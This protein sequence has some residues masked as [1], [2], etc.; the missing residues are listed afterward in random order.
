MAPSNSKYPPPGKQPLKH[1]AL[2]PPKELE[3]CRAMT[4]DAI[5]DNVTAFL[6]E[7]DPSSTEPSVLLCALEADDPD[8]MERILACVDF[9]HSGGKGEE[10]QAQAERVRSQKGTEGCWSA[11]SDFVEYALTLCFDC[12]SYRC[13]RVLV[14]GLPAVR[15]A[16]VVDARRWR[17]YLEDDCEIG[18]YLS[19]SPG[20]Q[21]ARTPISP[22]A[23]KPFDIVRA[24]PRPG[25]VVD[26]NEFILL[27]NYF[28]VTV[29][30]TVKEYW[31]FQI[32][33]KLKTKDNNDKVQK[34]T[35]VKLR[36]LIQR[37]LK[38]LE[39]A[40]NV[41]ASDLKSI[42]VAVQKPNNLSY[43]VADQHEPSK[44]YIV[45]L[46]EA[47]KVDI[48]EIVNFLQGMHEK[49][50]ASGNEGM[51]S[52]DA[53]TKPLEVLD[54]LGLVLSHTIRVQ[55]GVITIGRSRF[56]HTK[57]PLKWLNPKDKTLAI[58]S[59]FWQSV[60]PANNHFLLNVNVSN[61]AFLPSMSLQEYIELSR[62]YKE[63]ED[64]D[65]GEMMREY[66]ALASRLVG[67]RVEYEIGGQKRFKTIK[68]LV[69]IGEGKNADVADVKGQRF[70]LKGKRDTDGKL[71]GMSTR[72]KE[73]FEK[74]S[75]GTN[76]YKISVK[77]YFRL[78]GF[79]VIHPC[80]LV[81]Q[82]A[83]HDATEYDRKL[84]ELLPVI[85]LGGGCYVGAELC[86]INR[87]QL[88]RGD[89]GAEDAAKMIT[90]TVLDPE[91][92]KEKIENAPISLRMK[93]SK[94]LN[95]KGITRDGERVREGVVQ[96]INQM[97]NDVGE[98]A[99]NDRK[100]PVGAEGVPFELDTFED[101]A[102]RL[103]EHFETMN[104][105][106]TG[107]PKIWLVVLPDDRGL[108]NS[109]YKF[110]KKLGDVDYG[111]HT[112]S[113]IRSKLLKNN[114]GSGSIRGNI[115]LKF[116][117]KAGGINHL[118]HTDKGAGKTS[119]GIEL[120]GAGRTMVVGYDVSHPT[121]VNVPK[122]STT[123]KEAGTSKG[124]KGKEKESEEL[125][126]SFVGLVASVDGNLGQWPAV[127]WKT[128]TRVEMLDRATLRRKFTTRLKLWEDKNK[129]LP[130]N[131]VV[132][133]DGVSEGQY[134]EVLDTEVSAIK[135]AF[136]EVYEEKRRP[137]PGLLFIVTVKRHQ[138]RFFTAQTT[139]KGP[140]GN[141]RP[142]LAVD[143]GITVSR[144]WDFYLQPHAAI[145]GK[146]RTARPIHY[147]VL[148][149]DF[150]RKRYANNAASALERMT[151]DM[152]YA[153]GRATKA[154]SI[155]P[156]VYYADLVCTRAKIH[157]E[158]HKRRPTPGKGQDFD[159]LEIHGRC[160]NSMY[161]I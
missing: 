50:R 23:I 64:M 154:V 59:G 140:N 144:Q 72:L 99:R 93:D 158:E 121:G 44:T 46:I 17:G 77:D 81:I 71:I 62:W 151:H 28:R 66:R 7:G 161:Y 114:Q 67:A 1:P 127:A 6:W 10:L 88:F 16:L 112:I 138:T 49:W 109:I 53:Y 61:A 18:K 131:I 120:I 80:L 122:G 134:K 13:L 125:P 76:E 2:P 25:H 115:A 156:P 104:R 85:D 11:L 41:F 30:A 149:D 73:E 34:P 74:G 42:V 31:R 142:G 56:F 87:W 33:V 14:T 137:P 118:V 84:D 139:P 43:E 159:P 124:G 83:D 129:M 103:R 145:K 52:L 128:G 136:A 79:T 60:R 54:I 75:R 19:Q 27:A 68:G 51:D 117:L 9:E 78:R 65:R 133:R 97:S 21:Q 89:I 57:G 147:T 111:F 47:K 92:S 22:R 26:K 48:R 108:A 155:C 107:I 119:G 113:M 82:Y 5:R 70:T 24:P 146:T 8:L 94:L 100:Q 160:K 153:F 90:E 123:S 91:I 40:H 35:G 148:Y 15:E 152:C 86:K 126:P 37:A 39:P 20:A 150:F 130:E 32:D 58:L 102:R 69:E 106:G 36:D 12:K 110:V 132:Y 55:E 63:Y 101:I 105:K 141:P 96:L 3:L 157:W 45:T 4:P 135:D 116:N 143:N 95:D 29:E 38:H 98:L